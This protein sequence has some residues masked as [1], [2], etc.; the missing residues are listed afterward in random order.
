M[1]WRLRSHLRRKAKVAAVPRHPANGKAAG[2]RTSRR[3]CGL[4][5]AAVGRGFAL[6]RWTP[7][8]AAGVSGPDLRGEVHWEDPAGSR[9]VT[10]KLTVSLPP[11]HAASSSVSL[12]CLVGHIAGGS[13]WLQVSDDEVNSV[14]TTCQ[15]ASSS[16]SL[17]L[18]SSV[19]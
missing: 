6:A 12:A 13:S 8:R 9:L 7:A 10:T 1:S 17:A 2:T 16:V 3:R 19:T 15:A 5:P 18:A 14:A 4:A 11:A